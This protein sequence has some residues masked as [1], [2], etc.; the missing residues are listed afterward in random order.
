MNPSGSNVSPRRLCAGFLLAALLSGCGPAP[1]VVSDDV[2]TLR[3]TTAHYFTP[4][5]RVIQKVGVQPDI[6]VEMTD[7]Q[8][9]KVLMR[10]R[11]ERMIKESP[12]GTDLATEKAELKKLGEAADVQLERALDLLQGILAV[13]KPLG[14]TPAPAPAKTPAAG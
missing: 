11:L 5:G 6:R 2:P 10:R 14:A 3:L 12:E 9:I 4:K 13:R 1:E 7:E 8:E